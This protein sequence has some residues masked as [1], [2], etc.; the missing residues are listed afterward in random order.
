MR[1]G[2]QDQLAEGVGKL[3]FEKLGSACDEKTKSGYSTE[4]GE[5]LEKLNI[6]SCRPFWTIQWAWKPK[7]TYC[8]GLVKE[9]ADDGCIHSTFQNM[10]TATGRLVHERIRRISRAGTEPWQ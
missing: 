3:L 6:R 10:V 7:S 2:V 1:R 8:D 9:I 5:V 4:R